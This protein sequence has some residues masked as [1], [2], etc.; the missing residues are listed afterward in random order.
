MTAIKS[1]PADTITLGKQDK[2]PAAVVTSRSQSLYLPP[3]DS[4][5][6]EESPGPSTYVQGSQ[7]Q[8]NRVLKLCD[9]H[10]VCSVLSVLWEKASKRMKRHYLRKAEQSVSAVLDVIAPG[11]SGELLTELCSRH[12]FSVDKEADEQVLKKRKKRVRSF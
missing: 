11:A 7:Q 3:K 6:S 2:T 4:D 5:N 10:P 9:F 8:L 1:L 12:M